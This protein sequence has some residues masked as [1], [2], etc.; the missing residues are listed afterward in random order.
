[1]LYLSLQMQGNIE[2]LTIPLDEMVIRAWSDKRWSSYKLSHPETS[3]KKG[4][5]YISII[6]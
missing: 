6:R 4:K 1:M 5:N 2:F 3:Q